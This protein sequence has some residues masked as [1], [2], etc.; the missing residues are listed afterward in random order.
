MTM[1]Q[2]KHLTERH[3]FLSKMMS[4][5]CVKCASAQ[6]LKKMFTT[7]VCNNFYSV[8]FKESRS[9]MCD[10]HM[11]SEPLFGEHSNDAALTVEDAISQRV[12]MHRLE[13][14][15][16][17]VLHVEY[18]ATCS[19]GALKHCRC[20][21][22]GWWSTVTAGRHLLLSTHLF[23]CCL[24]NP[25][26][27]GQAR[28]LH[29]CLLTEATCKWFQFQVTSCMGRK[30]HLVICCKECTC[31]E[32]EG[33]NEGHQLPV[34]PWLLYWML[35]WMIWIDDFHRC[36]HH[37]HRNPC[38]HHLMGACK[39]FRATPSHVCPSFSCMC[40]LCHTICI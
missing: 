39:L 21:W 17:L 22:C 30:G 14:F 23:L 16:V 28:L 25:T 7:P 6:C 13:M 34:S 33:T 3:S 31:Q 40:T 5:L 8:T 26:V 36:H 32:N 35:Y 1:S 27:L 18:F 24:T 15:T 4:H 38:P 12:N 19:H 9:R 37:H 10:M 29:K 20:L 11:G 2:N